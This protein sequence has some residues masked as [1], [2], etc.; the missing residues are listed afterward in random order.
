MKLICV[1][2]ADPQKAWMLHQSF[3]ENENGFMNAAYGVSRD[4]FPIFMERKKKE[5][6]G[7]DLPQGYVPATEYLLVN[8]DNEY[9]G[10]FNLRHVLNDFLEKG[11]G[12]IGYGIAHAYRGRG[13]ASQGLALV[14]QEAEKLGIKTAYLSVDK[15]NLA[16]LQ[17]QKNNGAYIDHEDDQEYYTRIVID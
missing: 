9:V 11:P 1:W 2:D 13:Y 3:A 14:L 12:H 5:S 16:S 8:D 10:I 17:V 4:D 15:D 7:I 6:L